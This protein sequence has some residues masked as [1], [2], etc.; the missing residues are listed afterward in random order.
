[1][2][3]LPLQFQCSVTCGRGTK[4]RDVRC[5]V[6]SQ[7]RT[8]VLPAAA[9]GPVTKPTEVKACSRKHCRKGR[10]PRIRTDPSKFVQLEPTDSVHLTVGG[11]V[12]L[13]PETTLRIK[14]PV[15]HYNRK[16][17]KWKFRDKEIPAKGRVSVTRGGSLRMR[18]AR[19]SNT[20]SYQCVAGDQVAETTVR[21]HTQ[22]TAEKKRYFRYSLLA[23]NSDFTEN[24]MSAR[25]GE[26]TKNR[27]N[28]S[29]EYLRSLVRLADIPFQFVA[30]EWSLCSMTCGGAGLQRRHI[31]C[32]V[33]LPAYM[34]I[35]N[36]SFCRERGQEK[37]LETR[38]CGYEPCPNW[39]MGVW[40][41]VRDNSPAGQVT[42]I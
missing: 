38:D 19:T 22:H 8:D 23:G 18:Q 42:E 35:V 17:I 6:T 13:I 4:Q 15:S 3:S 10:R 34:L 24:V 16:K 25:R 1:M 29:F 30:W 26:R 28:F 12:Q 7:G 2:P 21:F 20:G 39:E 14:C 41:K 37:P 27:D 36:D 11:T 5:Q 31:A 40:E 32:E 33:V 9:C